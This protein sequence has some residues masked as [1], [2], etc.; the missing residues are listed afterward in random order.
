MRNAEVEQVCEG[1]I[2]DEDWDRL[3]AFRD[4]ATELQSSEW[5]KA[6]LDKDY[7]VRS[8]AAGR[9]I[10]DVPGR[11]TD[12]AVRELLLLLRPFV[13]QKEATSFLRVLGVLRRYLKHP[14]FDTLFER[15]RRVFLKGE[16]GLY[17]EIS[18]GGP[19]VNPLSDE[20]LVLNDS[21]T[22]DLW[23]NAFVYHRDA[24]KRKELLRHMGRKDDEL[25]LAAL[26]ALIADKAWMVL[27][28]ADFINDMANSP[29][30]RGAIGGAPDSP[31]EP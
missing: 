26:R 30:T 12:A 14:A 17:G 4:H 15:H 2:P 24:D 29:T 6:G 3:I 25:S 18:V 22:L 11:P 21:D 1:L 19:G 13:L 23:L 16:F 27:W 20:M 5:V 28:L 31:N 7:S 9:P 8:D 10:V